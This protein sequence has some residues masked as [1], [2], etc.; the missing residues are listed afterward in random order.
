MSSSW[1]SGA[2]T[3]SCGAGGCSFREG[4]MNYGAVK[5]PGS[6]TAAGNLISLAQFVGD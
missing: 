4:V 6:R 1:D 2:R 5:A 3:G